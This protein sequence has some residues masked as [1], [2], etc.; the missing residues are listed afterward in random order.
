[1]YTITITNLYSE[2]SSQPAT[3]F[4]VT[5]KKVIIGRDS[6]ND[7]V[8]RQSNVSS[9]HATLKVTRRGVQISDMNSSNGV[10]VNGTRITA[11]MIVNEDDEIVIG[12]SKIM[13]GDHSEKSASSNKSSSISRN[14]SDVSP[15][16]QKKSSPSHGSSSGNARNSEAYKY[17]TPLS[18]TSFPKQSAG[19]ISPL[20]MLLSGDDAKAVLNNLP[21]NVATAGVSKLMPSAPTDAMKGNLSFLLAPQKSPNREKQ[22]NTPFPNPTGSHATSPSQDLSIPID[23]SEPQFEAGPLD[24]RALTHTGGPSVSA[25]GESIITIEMTK[26]GAPA[27]AKGENRRFAQSKVT[28]GRSPQNDFPLQCNRTSNAHAQLEISNGTVIVTDRNSSNGTFV[29]GKRIEVPTPVGRNDQIFIGS[30]RLSVRLEEGS[31]HVS[32]RRM[33]P[34]ASVSLKPLVPAVEQNSQQPAPTSVQSENWPGAQAAT[35]SD[36]VQVP[37]SF[38]EFPDPVS[39]TASGAP[40]PIPGNAQLPTDPAPFPL[41]YASAGIPSG[42]MQSPFEQGAHQPEFPH[43]PSSDMQP[44][45]EAVPHIASLPEQVNPTTEDISFRNNFHSLFVSLTLVERTLSLV[46]ERAQ[47]LGVRQN[48]AL[49]KK[50]ALIAS[51]LLENHRLTPTIDD[52]GSVLTYIDNSVDRLK[53]AIGAFG[54]AS[55][56]SMLSGDLTRALALLYPFSSENAN[57]PAGP[58]GLPGLY[59][60][61]ETVKQPMPEMETNDVFTMEGDI[62]GTL[63]ARY[64]VLSDLC[65]YDS[66]GIIARSIADSFFLDPVKAQ[67]LECALDEACANVI[68]HAFEMNSHGQM[69]ISFFSNNKDN[70]LIVAVDDKGLPLDI[71]RANQGAIDGPGF[72]IM[73]KLCKWVRFVH[74]QQ[75]GKRIKFALELPS[76]FTGVFSPPQL[77]ASCSVPISSSTPFTVEAM[78]ATHAENV[79]R[80]LY[81]AYGYDYYEDAEYHP[82]NVRHLLDSGLQ[83]SVLAY[84]RER[85][86]VGHMC[87]LKDTPESRIAQL[88]K[89]YIAKPLRTSNMVSRL[90]T[91][92]LDIARSS[93][94]LGISVD[95]TLQH[96]WEQAAFK[97]IGARMTG[98]F[99]AHRPRVNPAGNATYSPN[100]R[101]T[102]LTSYLKLS[103]DL[104]QTVF[105]PVQYASVLQKIYNDLALEREI[106]EAPRVPQN[107]SRPPISEIQLIESRGQGTVIMRILNYGDDCLGAI[108]SKLMNYV[109]GKYS[110]IYVD[111]PLSHFATVAVSPAIE[112]MGFFLGGLVPQ[113]GAGDMI[114]LQ[115]LNDIKIDINSLTLKE[116]TDQ[117]L[118]SFILRDEQRVRQ[119]KD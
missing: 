58:I 90:A 82:G 66:I 14:R 115:Y 99:I 89:I 101:L 111:L 29:N 12:G 81:R 60:L 105:L 91:S 27:T 119:L 46:L 106:L 96:P 17:N 62:S 42:P 59:I 37:D 63:I 19:G 61:A 79:V 95:A 22:S 15:R 83:Q 6:R 21:K 33:P 102:V 43:P 40:F 108:K 73:R 51:I 2:N 41:D 20:S 68:T 7:I 26:V 35:T 113:T 75:H 65:Y 78:N 54:G 107:T 24:S 45:P 57:H 85:V 94:L 80:C 87:L 16:L 69:C 39:Q 1:M 9:K 114:R 47:D 74:L 93:G 118:I 103:S 4:Q 100:S 117:S 3:V 11:P 70:E 98:V 50:C 88:T 49:R 97:G 84:T 86:A 112:K 38:P 77:N 109:S 32:E 56:T 36:N 76:Q 34:R 31:E 23:F 72:S 13:L 52:L 53:K 25:S 18:D 71:E 92:L 30:F 44:I 116:P 8:L 67:Y 64:M 5:K 104:P 10:I 48:P 28:I 110:C 55:D